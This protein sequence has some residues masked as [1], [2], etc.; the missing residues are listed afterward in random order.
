LIALIP[1]LLTLLLMQFNES[2]NLIYENDDSPCSGFTSFNNDND[3]NNGS[4]S[5]S[6]CEAQLN[7]DKD[8]SN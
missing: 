1:S 3:C 7:F 8:I 6:F 4:Q 2:L 5:I